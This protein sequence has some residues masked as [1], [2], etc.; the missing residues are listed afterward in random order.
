MNLWTIAIFGIKTES[1]AICTVINCTKCE[2]CCSDLCAAAPVFRLQLIALSDRLAARENRILNP[3]VK[4][5]IGTPEKP[6]MLTGAK[7]S[8]GTSGLPDVLAVALSTL[9]TTGRCNR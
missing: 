6:E 9:R 4:P 8:F 2:P 5:Q 7:A 3:S 1:S